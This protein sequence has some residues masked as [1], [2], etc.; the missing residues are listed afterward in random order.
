[1]KY[2]PLFVSLMLSG[3]LLRAGESAPEKVRR[4][5][6]YILKEAP[7]YEK[8]KQLQNDVAAELDTL[9]A[10]QNAIR[11]RTETIALNHGE[12]TMALE[13]LSMEVDKQKAAEAIQ[14]Q[15]L[16]SLMKVVNRVR[17]DGVLRFLLDGSDLGSLSAR[18]R[19]LFRALKSHSLVAKD[20]EVRSKRL[21]ESEQRIESARNEAKVLWEELADQER[22]LNG[23]LDRKKQL[24]SQIGK[25]QAY[26]KAILTDYER[27]S[28]EIKQLFKKFEAQRDGIGKSTA[29]RGTLELFPVESG[30]IVRHFGR[31]V[32]EKFQTVVN[33]NGIEI[34]APHNA[35]VV[36]V[37][38]GVVE[39]EGWVRG[40]GN[41]II[42]HHGGGFYSVHAHLY[43]A[44][45]KQGAAV[46][47]GDTIGAVGDT[48][49]S[50]KPSLYFELR[51]DGK[52]VDPILY[53]SSR[54]MKNLT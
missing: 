53:F 37:L 43:N 46:K 17:R 19:I 38:D 5:K 3:V 25:Q 29:R 36:A 50:D 21:A 12:L 51:A 24:M 22:L 7:A 32:H 10:E 52:P 39:F 6:E 23:V 47:A 11:H 34:E 9:N 33:H 45:A 1:M 26:Y 13:N 28:K 42:I 16:V 4:L 31:E 8:R 30:R 44:A 48:G 18:A 15:R 35:P 14:K 20:M 49:N 27:A 41:M 54:A 40:M 2:L